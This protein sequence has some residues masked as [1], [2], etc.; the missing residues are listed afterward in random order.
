MRTNKLILLSFL[1]SAT[2]SAGVVLKV[3]SKDS[4]GKSVPKEVYYAQDGMMRIDSVDSKGNVDGYDLVRDGVIWRIDPRNRTF[5]RVDKDS[6]QHMMGGNSAKLDAMI[7]SLPP[8]KRAMMQQRLAQM[9]QKAGTEQYTF[10]DT[11]R[12]DHS[13]AYTC[14]V[15]SEDRAGKPHAEYCVVS[16]TS[17][18][19]GAELESAMS[20]SIATA[21]E[22]LSG[23]PALAR[24]GERI[25]RLGKMHGFPVRSHSVSGSGDETVLA[26]AEAQALPADK[27]AIPQGFTEKPLGRGDD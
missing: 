21:N 1:V 14:R 8:E 15:W 13:G 24:Q 27:F 11:G 18:P 4:A 22:V 12:S 26:S 19:S 2:A 5:T 7:A 9:Q 20:K 16:F 10:T 6:M 25:T 23:V 3:D 17:L